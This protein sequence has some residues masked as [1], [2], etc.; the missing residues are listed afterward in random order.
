MSSAIITNCSNLSAT[1][2]VKMSEP[3]TNAMGGQ[4][5]YLNKVAGSGKFV[6]QLKDVT[7][8]F[9]VSS[10]QT[11]Q[12]DAPA[13]LSIDISFRDLPNNNKLAEFH[14]FVSEVDQMVMKSACDGLLGAP[15]SMEVVTELFKKTI[16][17]DPTGKYS[18]TMKFNINGSTMGTPSR[19]Y[20]DKK[21][22]IPLT[23]ESLPKGAKIDVIVEM[24]AV[25]IIGKK[26]LGITW[27]VPQIRIKEMGDKL[28]D[29]A[30][31]DSDDEDNNNNLLGSSYI[32]YHQE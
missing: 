16:R 18:D 22:E 8:P 3:R 15:K 25:Y 6:F 24:G 28:E 5:V 32:D 9:G 14:R 23:P 26:N 4:S 12:A 10:F 19:L 30:F 29:Y 17:N 1:D 20:N 13:K 2:H 31:I 21:E 27:R 11:D 7:V